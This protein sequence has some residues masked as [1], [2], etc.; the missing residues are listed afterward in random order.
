MRNRNARGAA[1][2][3]R[4]RAVT[5]NEEHDEALEEGRAPPR[6]I[7]S[8]GQLASSYAPMRHFAFENGLGVCIALPAPGSEPEGLTNSTKEQIRWRLQE[9]ARAWFEQGCRF[10]LA[11]GEKGTD[12]EASLRKMLVDPSLYD[13][14]TGRF[15]F[16]AELFG[17]AKPKD[18]GYEPSPTTLVC[19]KCG[20][21]KC[22]RD[23]NGMRVG[24]QVPQ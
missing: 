8:V 7:R 14:A 23:P 5:E 18:M 1:V 10:L 22:C 6:M 16:R 20:L 9:A 4:T 3:G 19:G 11:Q 12:R 24:G 15:E 2:R 17:F 21:L 13:E